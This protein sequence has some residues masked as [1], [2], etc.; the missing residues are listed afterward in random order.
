LRQYIDKNTFCEKEI[1]TLLA[2]S[3]ITLMLLMATTPL[4][5]LFNLVPA[6][7]QTPVSFRTTNESAADGGSGSDSN[8][9]FRTPG[10]VSGGNLGTGVIAAL[11][12][13]PQGTQRNPHV[14]NITS[15]TMQITSLQGGGILYRYPTGKYRVVVLPMTAAERVLLYLLGPNMEKLRLR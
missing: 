14:V 13:D 1:S 12:F 2:L 3:A 11:T 5:L 8:L 7:A 6:Q 15:G 4:R 9:S 10:P